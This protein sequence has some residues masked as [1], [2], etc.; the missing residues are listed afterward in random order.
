[1]SIAE[2]KLAAIAAII[3]LNDKKALKEILDR[4][5]ELIQQEKQKT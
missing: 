3:K 1:M 2:M 5:D 4:L